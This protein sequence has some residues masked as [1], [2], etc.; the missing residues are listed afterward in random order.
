MRL[1]PQAK[2]KSA[3]LYNL[4]VALVKGRALAILRGVADSNGL[5]VWRQLVIKYEPQQAARYSQ[6]L[7]GVLNPS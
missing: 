2:Q 3:L 6:M 5:E 4:L 1:G 7:Q